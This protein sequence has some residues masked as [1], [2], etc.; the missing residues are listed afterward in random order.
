M[1]KVKVTITLDKALRIYA[2][3]RKL[4]LSEILNSILKDMLVKDLET[5]KALKGLGALFS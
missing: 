5:K 4:N 3:E 2:E 1:R